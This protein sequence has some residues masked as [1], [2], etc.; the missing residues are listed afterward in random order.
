MK[1]Q[2]MMMLAGAALVVA[3]A[4]TFVTVSADS[5][6]TDFESFSLGNVNGQNGWGVGGSFDQG[7]VANTYSYP[8]FGTKA[9][10]I[11]DA[12]TSGSFGDQ[13]FT[14]S[15]ANEAGEADATSDG[16]SGGVRQSHFEAKFDIASTTAAYQPG[17]H[18]SVS[19]DRGDGARMSYLRF[20]DMADGIHVYF[21]D[22]TDPGHV[23]NGESFNE[24]DIAT[25]TRN[26]PHTVRFVI[27]FVNGPDNDVVKIYIDGTLKITGTT[28]ED[29]FRFDTE[30]NPNLEVHSRTVD[31]LLFREGGDANS[32]DIGMGFL[33]DN[34]NLISSMAPAN[35]DACKNNGWKA[36]TR[37]DGSTFKNQGDCIQYVNTGK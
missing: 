23:T 4:T 10:R 2:R 19:P 27:D 20:D 31:S 3:L 8:S 32:N 11:S 30:S 16:Y 28:W 6:S 18:V 1:I 13:T 7:V 14:K 33:F 26:A 29:Y 37:N 35:A 12:V 15:L 5:W 9:F 25:L 24:T 36:R 21:V 22:V 34:F 17:M